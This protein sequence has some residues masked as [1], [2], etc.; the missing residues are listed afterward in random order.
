[1]LIDDVLY[2]GRSVRAA[3]NE[4]FDYGRPARVELAVL[5]D[6]GGRELPIEAT[7]AGARLAVARNLSIVLSRNEEGRL[8]L[9]TE[10]SGA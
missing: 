6:R 3:V 1:V 4:L 9:G 2:T 5:V 8:L 7:Y 10:A